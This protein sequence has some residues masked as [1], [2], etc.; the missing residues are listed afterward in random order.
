VGAG[1]GCG[2]VT[3]DERWLAAVWPFVRAW[4]PGPPAEVLEIGCG[5]LGGFVPM[6]RSAGYQA[7]GVDPEAP[8][9]QWYHRVEFERFQVP[10]PARA[11]VACTSLHHVADV[12]EVLALAGAAL[13]AHATLV[14][15]EWARERFD[16]ATAR[17]CFQRLPQP[18]GDPGWLHQRCDGWRASG[19]SWDG[20]FRTW[21]A[22]EGLHSGR[23]IVR[24]LDARFDRQLLAYGPYFFPDLADV[25]ENEEQA[26]IDA[27]EIQANRISY[28]SRQR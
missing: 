18:A 12:G 17:W 27:G 25:S 6:L 21:A 19:L 13:A 20:Y 24:E 23:E 5:P 7:T 2:G 10:E 22:E 28:V 16:E 3:P 26:A 4:L 1:V 8:E 15:V 14:V 11:V 9:G